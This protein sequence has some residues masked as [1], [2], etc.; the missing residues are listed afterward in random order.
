MNKALRLYA[1][2]WKFKHPTTADWIA[3]VNDATGRDYRWFFERTFFSS[4]AVD[5]AVEEATSQRVS[6]PRGLFE[7]DG[8]LVETPP[9]SLAS[10]KGWD[11]VARRDRRGD[12]AMPVEVVLR[13]EGGRV[14]RAAWDGEARWKR[15]RT[16]GGRASS[17]RQSTRARRSFSTSIARTTAG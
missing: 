16:R 14:H 15:F 1:D 10:P 12:V 7:A 4:G 17:R 6:V 8:R 5:Y 3:A 2:R 9:A 11:S 13:F